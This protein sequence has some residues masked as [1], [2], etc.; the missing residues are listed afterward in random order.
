MATP[1]EWQQEPTQDEAPPRDAKPS[2]A[3]DCGEKLVGAPTKPTNSTG[4]PPV[5]DGGGSEDEFGG[6]GDDLDDFEAEFGDFDE[7]PTIVAVSKVEQ[8]GPSIDTVLN[9][10]SALFAAAKDSEGC[11]ETIRKCLAQVIDDC[12]QLPGV[13]AV[14]ELHSASLTSRE[15][16]SCIEGCIEG[17]IESCIESSVTALSPPTASELEP[18]LLQNV[19]V[20]A[21]STKLSDDLRMRLLTPSSELS[22]EEAQLLDEAPPTVA[23]YDIDKVRQI[24]SG[25]EQLAPAQLKRALSSI[26][27]LIADQEQEVARRKDA[28]LAYN[29]VIQTLVAQAS[30][31]H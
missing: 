31:L 23:L 7:A 2:E 26:N 9:C 12:D 4:A 8:S 25:S 24:V 29:Q 22:A 6:F 11:S 16:E 15:L 28:V 30:K 19:L 18:R 14:P 27:A 21:L 3:E 20:V 1:A 17:C 5:E 10:T 13:S